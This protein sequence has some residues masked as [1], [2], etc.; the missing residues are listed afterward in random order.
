MD[1]FRDGEDEENAKPENSTPAARVRRA[2]GHGPFHTV[3]GPYAATIGGESFAWFGASDGIVLTRRVKASGGVYVNETITAAMGAER[4]PANL[5]ALHAWLDNF[6][7]NVP[8]RVFGVPVDAK[9]LHR[10]FVAFSDAPTHYATASVQGRTNDGTP[11]AIKV[12]VLDGGGTTVG[13]TAL[14]DAKRCV[15]AWPIPDGVRE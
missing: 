11:T 1:A 8:V 10:A 9:R 14:T 7:G 2:L 5:L 15:A 13:I 3:A 12:F 4:H 6:D